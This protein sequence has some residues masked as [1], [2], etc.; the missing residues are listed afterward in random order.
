MTALPPVA[1]SN[2][3][4]KTTQIKTT[5]AQQQTLT[6]TLRR[7]GKLSTLQ[8]RCLCLFRGLFRLRVENF[9]EPEWF[10]WVAFSLEEL[11]VELHP[12]M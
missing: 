9:V 11:A 5:T 6:V 7:V 3:V 8:Q 1:P 12:E 10:E 2:Y 4:Y